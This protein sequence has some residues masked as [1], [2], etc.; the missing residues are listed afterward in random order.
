MSSDFTR[1]NKFV[2]ENTYTSTDDP[3]KED[4]LQKYQERMERLSQQNR[5]IKICTDAVKTTPRMTRVRDVQRKSY[6][7]MKK[8]G[9]RT[10]V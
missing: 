1:A 5:V 8:L 10:Y 7:N 4:L 9:L 2:D 6:N 3:A